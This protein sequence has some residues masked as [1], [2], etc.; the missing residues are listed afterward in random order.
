MNLQGKTVLITGANN[1]IGIGAEAARALARRGA[2]IALTYLQMPAESEPPAEPGLAFYH[3]QRAKSADEVVQSIVRNGGAAASLQLDLGRSDAARALF[4]WAEVSFGSVDILINN[5]AHCETEGDDI[6]SM[7]AAGIDR[8]FSVNVRAALLLSQEYIVRH[9]R[10]EATWG[11]VI[12]LSADSAQCFAGQITYGASKA[13]LEALTRSIA[14]AVGPHGITVNA[15]APGPVQTGYITAEVAAA[16]RPSIPSGRIGTPQDIAEA[17][18]FLASD[19]AD[20]ITGQ[21]IRVSGG[22]EL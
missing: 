10:R 9:L 22:Y 7:T 13:A 6:G 8:T 12:N 14:K 4:D 3:R 20:W 18:L 16:L 19:A 11:R 21:V 17:I 15:I 1:P 2:K 5:A